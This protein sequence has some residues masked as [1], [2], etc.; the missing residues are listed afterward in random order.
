MELIPKGCILLA[1]VIENSDIWH[2][3][4][5]WLKVWLHILLKVNYEDGKSLKKGEGYFNYH[6]VAAACRVSYNTVAKFVQYGKTRGNLLATQKATRGTIIKVLNYHIYQDL[7]NYKSNAKS[8]ESATPAARQKQ[9]KSDTKKERNKKILTSLE[10]N[11]GAPAP[12]EPPKVDKRRD[13]ITK[14]LVW[15]KE[16]AGVQAFAD[17]SIERNIAKTFLGFI[18]KTGREDFLRRLD[19]VLSDEFKKQNRNRI[20]FLY[21]EVKSVPVREPITQKQ[22]CPTNTS[23]PPSAMSIDI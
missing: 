17:S 15:L 16:K 18:A 20:R 12:T 10:V 5:D 7:E 14:F 11:D 9:D 21:N 13:D 6:D 8:N 23:I 4:S 1:R 2:R 3:P 22:S 19:T